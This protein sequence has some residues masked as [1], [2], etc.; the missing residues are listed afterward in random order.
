MNWLSKHRT[1]MQ[2]V[3]FFAI[4]LGVPAAFSLALEGYSAGIAMLIIN[5]TGLVL[6]A[7]ELLGE[8]A[9][10]RIRR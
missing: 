7:R 1:L 8:T 2:W 5:T 10:T 6:A 9:T 4:A 3:P